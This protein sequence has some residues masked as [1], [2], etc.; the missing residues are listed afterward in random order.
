[1][2]Y[3]AVA[4]EAARFLLE[5]GLVDSPGSSSLYY[6]TRAIVSDAKVKQGLLKNRC[7]VR[8]LALGVVLGLALDVAQ[9]PASVAHVGQSPCPSR[10]TIASTSSYLDLD[11]LV[12]EFT[13]SSA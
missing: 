7:P 13:M 12:I 2:M 9:F 3:P 6:S 1:M 10:T 5:S 11:P 4:V 8:A